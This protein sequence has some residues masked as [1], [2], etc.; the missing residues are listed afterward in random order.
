MPVL[1]TPESKP[2]ANDL[3]ERY[4]LMIE[5]MNDGVWD[6]N[7]ITGEVF[8]STRWKTMLGYDEDE[9]PPS[10]ESWS[11]I[12]H[13][14][15]KARS[16]AIVENV[17]KSNAPSFELD[18][19]LR[20]KDGSYRWIRTRGAA[21]RDS[22]GKVCRLAGSHT[23]I[24]EKKKSEEMLEQL[25]AAFLVAIDGI[26]FRSLTGEILYLN[27][28]FAAIFGYE[29]PDELLGK[30][31]GSLHPDFLPEDK[32]V[33]HEALEQQGHWRGDMVARRRDGSLFNEGLS[34][35]LMRGVGVVC[36]CRD[37]TREKENEQ[38][39]R[40]LNE[41]LEKGVR[42]RTAQL[43]VVIAELRQSQER[44]E[45][46]VRGT[47]DGL[48]EWNILTNEN[49]WSERWYE[50]LG[51]QPGELPQNSNTFYHQLHPE[52]RG[53]V[54]QSVQ[55]HIEHH[56]PYDQE[57][58]MRTKSGDYRWFRA[59]GQAIWDAQ[60][61]PTRMAGSISDVSERKLDEEKML[62]YQE[63]LRAISAK[64]LQSE[65]S[66]RRRIASNIH[67]QVGQ[68]LAACRIQMGALASGLENNSVK[69]E[70]DAIRELLEQ[71]IDETRSLTFDLSPPVLNELG[72]VP[73]LQWL[74]EKNTKPGKFTVHC[75]TSAR[76][77]LPD[78]LKVLLFRITRE[79]LQNSI[80]H[81]RA[82]RVEIKLTEVP[83]GLRLEV[84][85]DGIGF[86]PTASTASET[87]GGFGLFS[88]RDRLRYIG[89]TLEL[90]SNPG[91]GTR[92]AVLVPVI[93]VVAQK[94]GI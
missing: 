70:A 11:N 25:H 54:Y 16:F 19:R 59:R 2:P 30:H 7:V 45:L 58:Q 62:A 55:A 92:A 5:G 57:F 4:A 36:V 78:M 80:K 13:P 21:Q 69:R 52:D 39:L 51:Y 17:V 46:A 41:E 9:I 29:N 61:R 65:E 14:D 88:I 8:Y 63:Q 48:W 91:K 67:D 56:Q 44:Y 71:A 82:S 83:G 32:K 53:R 12:L 22:S 49:Y 75:A 64:L 40:R 6:W 42:E 79:L 33:I 87:T 74:A 27:Q 60:G 76:M 20:H 24:T 50:L 15:D 93:E 43:D 81:A 1:P 37:I 26:A 77:E 23:D 34:L 38:K 47:N 31:F 85:D 28:S 89:G 84:S 72:L 94:G 68:L 35:T 10:F 90:D 18:H 3:Q 73:A 66:E 86:N